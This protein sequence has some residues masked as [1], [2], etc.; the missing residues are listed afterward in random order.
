MSHYERLISEHLKRWETSMMY[1]LRLAKARQELLIK[2]AQMYRDASAQGKSELPSLSK[3]ALTLGS[4]F[5]V[6]YG[7]ILLALG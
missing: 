2:A 6:V 5:V 7:V 3:F 1:E 4:G